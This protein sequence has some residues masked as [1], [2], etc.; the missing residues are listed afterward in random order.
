MSTIYVRDVKSRMARRRLFLITLSLFAAI[1]IITTFTF[2]L[3]DNKLNS[4]FNDEGSSLKNE[5][6]YNYKTH[7]T[8]VQYGT[9]KGH[10]TDETLTRYG[11]NLKLNLRHRCPEGSLM[12]SAKA[13]SYRDSKGKTSKCP[14][15]F[16]IG[17]K[18]GG[19]TSLYQYLSMHPDFSGIGINDTKWVGETFYFAQRYGQVSL[20]SY[21]NLFP[22]R[23]M[24][25]DASVDNLLHCKAPF[26][27]LRT[28]GG[29]NTKVIILLRHPIQRYVSNFMMR[30]VRRAYKLHSNSSSIHDQL[31]HDIKLL[32]QHLGANDRVY[33]HHASEWSKLLCLFE[34]CQNI[35]YEGLYY[36]FVMNWLCNF[37]KE[38]ILFI[39]SEEMFWR[40][41]LILKQVLDFV[42]LKPLSTESLY[43]IT[44]HLYNKGVKPFLPQH[45]MSPDDQELLLSYY[46]IFNDAIFDLLDWKL[47]WS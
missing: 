15:V 4:Q 8:V 39:N 31:L 2:Y 10:F 27:I 20:N 42:G 24:S 38:N 11:A 1:M 17:T 32:N 46:S 5:G 19:T 6:P 43:D 30:V 22:K 33:P 21:L 45:H 14:K 18:K 41:A 13:N 12:V 25:G 34:C 9:T 47:N 40:P 28:C 7:G 35:L 37:P 26:R 36:V 16:I 44:S 3:H 23:K 29:R